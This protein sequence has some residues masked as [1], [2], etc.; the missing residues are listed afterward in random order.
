MVKK[1]FRVAISSDAKAIGLVRVL[2]WQAAFKSLMPND[3]LSALNPNE[4]LDKLE[5]LILEDKQ[6]RV[7]VAEVNSELVGF[8]ILG[9]PRYEASVK[10]QEVWALY[11]LPTQWRKGIGEGL[12]RFAIGARQI[13]EANRIEL[14]CLEGNHNARAFYSKA[15][16]CD[17]G[18]IRTTSH[19]I[20]EPLTEVLYRYSDCDDVQ[21]LSS[22]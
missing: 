17:T 7:V 11:V 19:L 1:L 4:N 18:E 13:S 21:Q 12:I 3:Y 22:F 8:C 16:F 2:A 10:C 6:T 14:W 20:N 5:N 9:Q 15:G